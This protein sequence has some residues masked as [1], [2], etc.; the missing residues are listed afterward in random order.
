[1][2][3]NFIQIGPA[4]AEI[5]YDVIFIFQDGGSDRLMVL[6]VSHLRTKSISKPIIVDISQLT[7]EI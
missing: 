3:L 5:N 7:T 4:A 2:L 1:M 6:L